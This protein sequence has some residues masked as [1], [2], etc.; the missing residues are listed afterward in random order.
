MARFII[1][2]LADLSTWGLPHELASIVP[3]TPVALQTIF[4]NGQEEYAMFA[5]LKKRYRWVL[6]PYRYDKQETLLS[7]LDV[8]V[9]GPAEAKARA[10]LPKSRRSG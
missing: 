8:K 9:I 10:L 7:N 3:T 6:N 5:D 1:A 2:D 4:Q